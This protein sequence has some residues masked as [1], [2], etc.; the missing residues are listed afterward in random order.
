MQRSVLWALLTCTATFTAPLL[1]NEKPTIKKTK[2][3]EYVETVIVKGQKNQANDLGA[4]GDKNRIDTPFSINV[5]DAE[6]IVKRGAKSVRQIFIN[7]PA[8]YT[9]AS[10]N[11][12]D[13]WG[14]TLRGMPV[15]N[16]YADDYPVL[17]YWGGDFPVEVVDSVTA[18]KGATGFMYGFGSPGGA[19]SYKLKKPKDT[20]HSSLET[21]VRSNNV[22]SAHLDTGGLLSEDM[23]YRFNLAAENGTAYNAAGVN[24]EVGSLGFEKDVGDKLEW[25]TN[26]IFERSEL[27]HEPYQIYMSEYDLIGSKG[28][29]PKVTYDYRDFNVNDAFYETETLIASTG[30]KYQINDN[31]QAK[32]QYGYSR[33][34]HDSNKSFIDLYNREGDYGGNI[35]NFYGLLANYFSQAMLTGNL[36]TGHIK[37]E[38]VTGIGYQKSTSQYGP[39]YYASTPDFYGNIFEEQPFLMGNRPDLTLNPVGSE[40]RQTYGFISDT[41]HLNPRWQ[42]ILGA[43]H[44]YYDRE[45]LN[46]SPVINSG[47]NTTALTPTIALIYKPS[48][49]STLYTSY[50]EGLEP[51]SIVGTRYANRDEVLDA[52][53]SNQ[54]EAG[55]KYLEGNISLEAAIFKVE[56]AE[57]MDVTRNGLVY[58]TQDGLTTFQGIEL[59]GAYQ[60]TSNMR[61]GLGVVNLDASIEYVS[62]ANRAIEGNQPA[63]AAE[64]QYAVNAEYDIPAIEGLSLRAVYRY[65]GDV[66]LTNLN[67]LKIPDY[68]VINTGFSYQFKLWNHDAT[69]NGNINNVLNEKYWAGGGNNAV[70]VG[71]AFNTSIGLQVNW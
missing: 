50:V 42:L 34:K 57:T 25:I 44:T 64:W 35:Y 59:N 48:E 23:K 12:T 3:E 69:L 36:F 62:I 37:H 67:Q 18:L 19:V 46:P 61:M 2:K 26:V 5:I 41:L 10:S 70:V 28:K 53:V 38:I 55:A 15:R 32:Y 40:T 16:T 27:E 8:F 56:R 52:R 29:M 49:N 7:D 31:W 1:A 71:E 20:A 4:F 24:R 51:G 22:F 14:M 63:N 65:Y 66:Y 45:D 9:P 58:L 54:Y 21:G 17:L 30:F 68:S 39:F 43:R 6:D 13:W 47:Y 60:F 33:K 11:T